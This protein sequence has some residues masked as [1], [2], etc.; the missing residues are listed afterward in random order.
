ML[1]KPFFVSLEKNFPLSWLVWRSFLPTWTCLASIIILVWEQKKFFS[2]CFLACHFEIQNPLKQMRNSSVL[3]K[4]PP[5]SL[6][7]YSPFTIHVTYVVFMWIVY[8]HTFIFYFI[9]TILKGKKILSI[10]FLVDQGW[11]Y[12][13]LMLFISSSSLGQY[14]IFY[15]LLALCVSSWI[16]SFVSDLRR[17]FAFVSF[18]WQES[19]VLYLL[20][21]GIFFWVDLSV[22]FGILNYSA[23]QD[24]FLKFFWFNSELKVSSSCWCG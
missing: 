2:F 4:F 20:G 10:S 9:H 14:D 6:L 3:L 16:L 11:H 24:S 13:I 21:K 1:K 15:F 7:S 22:L 17:C 18:D 8:R 23:L 12:L 19:C 5:Y